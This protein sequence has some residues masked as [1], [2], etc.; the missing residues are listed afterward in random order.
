[1]LIE[2]AHECADVVWST[3]RPGKKR[4][5]RLRETRFSSAPM[6][7]IQTVEPNTFVQSDR[8]AA[9]DVNNSFFRDPSEQ[10]G[11]SAAPHFKA[12]R[13]DKVTQMVLLM[14]YEL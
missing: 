14:P 9:G 8:D 7:L 4:R 13:I 1:M 10:A 11:A 6:S 5:L 3:V 12:D 2:S